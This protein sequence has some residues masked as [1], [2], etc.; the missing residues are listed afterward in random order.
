MKMPKAVDILSE[1]QSKNAR[2]ERI[3]DLLASALM[4]HLGSHTHCR[5]LQQLV[6]EVSIGMQLRHNMTHSP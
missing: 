1:L 6:E 3:T 2:L 5:F 4:T